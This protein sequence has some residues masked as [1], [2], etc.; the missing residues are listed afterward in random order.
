MC[1]AERLR[2]QQDSANVPKTYIYS[3]SRQDSIRLAGMHLGL[4]AS[5]LR[6]GFML[7]QT[8]TEGI[9]AA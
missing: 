9:R 1:K 4:L 8:E 5:D 6:L 7:N 3:N 2:K